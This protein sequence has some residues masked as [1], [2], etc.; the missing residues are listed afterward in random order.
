ML[1]KDNF[2]IITGGPGTGK[3]TLL[4]ELHVRGYPYV[5]EVAR[6]LIKDQLEANGDA[7]PWKDARYYSCLMLGYSIRDFR[8]LAHSQH[9]SF[10]DR[11]IPD[12]YGYEILMDFAYNDAL[13]QALQEYRY[14]T[15]VFILPFWKDIYTTDNERKQ[16]LA[17]AQ[18]TYHALRK[19]YEQAGYKLVEVPLVPVAERA[20]F[21][22]RQIG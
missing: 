6:T 3:T 21:V 9:L 10:F 15:T 13:Q 2:Y 16:D 5:P 8:A 17:E 19:A 11:G 4:Q 1:L 12:T 14:N 18:A 7:L 22:L 20:D